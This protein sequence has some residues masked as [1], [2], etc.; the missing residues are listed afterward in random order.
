MIASTDSVQLTVSHVRSRGSRLGKITRSARRMRKESG[1]TEVTPP[2]LS[3]RNRYSSVVSGQGWPRTPQ[4]AVSTRPT[5]CVQRRRR[6]LRSRGKARAIQEPSTPPTMNTTQ[7]KWMRTTRSAAY[8]M[9]HRYLIIRSRA[10]GHI[11]RGGGSKGVGNPLVSGLWLKALGTG[12]CGVAVH[13]VPAGRGPSCPGGGPPS[14]RCPARC[15]AVPEV[16]ECRN[17]S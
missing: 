10:P 16:G 7:A 2:P 17:N 13:R 14:P 1:G 15:S 5:M 11:M 8:S 3:S 12:G 9:V 6:S 4:D